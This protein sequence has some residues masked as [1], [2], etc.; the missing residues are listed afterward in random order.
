MPGRRAHALSIL[1]RTKE[2]LTFAQLVPAWARELAGDKTDTDRTERDLGHV[3]LEDIIKGRLDD[4]GPPVDGRQFGIRLITSE[5]RSGFLEGRQVLELT[6][7]GGLP[8]EI[9]HRIVLLKPAVLDFARRRNL[10]LPSWWADLAEASNEQ[11]NDLATDGP[12]PKSSDETVRQKHGARSVQELEAMQSSTL[13]WVYDLLPPPSPFEVWARERELAKRILAQRDREN[14]ASEKQALAKGSGAKTYLPDW[15]RLSDALARILASG[16]SKHE[17]QVGVCR[18]IADRKIK[19][20]YLIANEE[21][22]GIATP[23]GHGLAG[24]VL[25]RLDIIPAR[26]A[27]RDFDW[28]KSRPKKPW[29]VS[30]NPVFWHLDWIEVFSGDITSVLCSGRQLRMDEV[31]LYGGGDRDRDQKA[32]RWRADRILRFSENQKRT[33]GW[34]NFAEIAEWCSELSGLVVPD[35]RARSSAYEKLQRDLLEGDFE[36]NGRSRVFYL[37]PSTV[38]ARMTRKWLQDMVSMSSPTTIRREYF[39]HCWLP[40]SLFQRWLAKHEMPACP[41]RFEPK[42]ETPPEP[43][44]PWQADSHSLK[45]APNKEISAAIKAAY[46]AADAAGRKPPNIKELPAAVQPRLEENGYCASARSIQKV[47]EAQE[48]KRRRRQPGRTISS[49]QRGHH[50]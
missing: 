9:C 38:K 21:I 50:K 2:W 48:F 6:V 1:F 32:R 28:R 36:E 31:K 40:R 20:R 10:P 4:T 22:G 15:E 45:P 34:I 42:V 7:D 27:P 47:G 13:R 3:L 33:R 37:H 24:H 41:Q 18:A 14:P 49:E 43:V 44:S 29:Q 19:I 17:A 12:T 16:L 30:P 5:N 25:N 8:A 26:L 39:D 11:T 46:D 35:E 23:K